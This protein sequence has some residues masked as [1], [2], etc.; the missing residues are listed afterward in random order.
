MNIYHIGQAS[1]PCWFGIGE[2]RGELMIKSHGIPRKGEDY[3]KARDAL[4]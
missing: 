4:Q 2:T 1:D 3:N